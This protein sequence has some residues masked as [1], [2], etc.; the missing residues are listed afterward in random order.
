MGQQTSVPLNVTLAEA[1]KVCVGNKLSERALQTYRSQFIIF[2]LLSCSG[3]HLR[4]YDF[5]DEFFWRQMVLGR[6]EKPVS[7]LLHL[8][9]ERMWVTLNK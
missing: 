8:C 9:A 5:N 3:T 1:N 7:S 6:N 2:L 4:S